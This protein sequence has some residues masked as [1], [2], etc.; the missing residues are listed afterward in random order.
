MK[1]ILVAMIIL[2][3]GVGGYVGFQ[4]WKKNRYDAAFYAEKV[5]L[6]LQNNQ[7]QEAFNFV[8]E[9]IFLFPQH[10]DLRFGK[11]YMCQMLGDVQCI[12]DEMLKIL[13][14]SAKNNNQWLWLNDEP[15]DNEFMLGILQNYQ[16]DFWENGNLAEMREI[17]EA[18]LNYFPD[19]VESLNTLAISYLAEENWQ[20][21]E[22]YLK[23]AHQINPDDEIVNKN[24]QKL[25]EM[26]N[27][28]SKKEQKLENKE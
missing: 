20:D 7:P 26:K 19:N 2:L 22:P 25:T 16:K 10:L 23:T 13:Q 28:K 27:N 21:A 3:I 6:A 4:V 8:N 14:F 17:A 9:G 1:K 18:V 11:T 15:K 5:N 12:K 24:L